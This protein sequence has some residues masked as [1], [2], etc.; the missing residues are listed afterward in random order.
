M[1]MRIGRV[2][3]VDA[4]SGKVIVQYPDTG[5]VSLPLSVVTTGGEY[6]MPAVGS[7]VLTYHMDNGGSKGFVIGNYYSA[8]NAPKSRSGYRKDISGGVYIT[9]QGGSYTL[10]ADGAT[11]EAD[12]I[13]LKCGYGEITVEQIMKRLEAIE[14]N[15]GL[16]HE[17]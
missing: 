17:V 2:T 16:P 1:G 14:D 5:N 4:A 7:Q 3:G 9:A 6:S 8:A 13:T 12:D 10:H 15:L 11:I